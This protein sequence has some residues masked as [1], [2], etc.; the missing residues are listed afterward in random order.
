MKRI[1]FI[2]IISLGGYFSSAQNTPVVEKA[3]PKSNNAL[4]SGGTLGSNSGVNPMGNPGTITNY[5]SNS[6]AVNDKLE[7]SPNIEPGVFLNS[8]PQGTFR[9]TTVTNGGVVQQ[10]TTVTN[11]GA[12]ITAVVEKKVADTATKLNVAVSTAKPSVPATE[13]SI[14]PVNASVDKTVKVTTKSGTKKQVRVVPVLGNYVPETI[15]EN[16]KA[17]YGSAVYSIIAVRVATSTKISYLV[18]L[19]K[20]G[21]TSMEL[22]SE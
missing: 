21:K 20:D 7:A 6:N 4:P 9:G 17:K 11:N 5:S 16:I 13:V 3:A 14:V 12:A 18:K 2:I 8:S 1:I 22:Y 10:Q 19:L 15:V